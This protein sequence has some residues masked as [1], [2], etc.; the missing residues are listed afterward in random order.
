MN[1]KL[2]YIYSLYPD[3]KCEL[4]YHNLFELVIAVSLSAQTTDKKVNLATKELFLK[5]PTIIDLANADIEDVKRIVRPIGMVNVK[6]KNIIE[7]AK[8]IH[9]DFNDKIPNNKDLLMGLPGVGNKTAN[10]V[11]AEGF[12]MNEFPVDTHINRVAKRLQLA[13]VN[14]LVE[15][16]EAKLKK[17]IEP[18]MYLQMHHS[19][20][21]FGRY[22]CKAISP[23]CLNCKLKES[24]NK[25]YK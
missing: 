16:V 5:Y 18:E 21:Y 15:A 3:A 2:Q 12:K 7:I 23:D 13:D 11:L 1:E 14:D 22:M 19:L 20:I 4:I 10:V 25:N 6:S 9:N 24:C 8:I 17:Q